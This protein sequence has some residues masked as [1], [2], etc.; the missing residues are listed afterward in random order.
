MCGNGD[1]DRQDIISVPRDN[2]RLTNQEDSGQY[3]VTEDHLKELSVV[4]EMKRIM[5]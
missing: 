3:I 2:A 4:L 5:S 1:G